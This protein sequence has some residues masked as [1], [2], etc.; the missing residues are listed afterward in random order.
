MNWLALLGT[1]L[2]FVAALLLMV[3]FL[4]VYSNG[5]LKFKTRQRIQDEAATKYGSNPALAED[6]LTTRQCALL[7]LPFLIVGTALLV[8]G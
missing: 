3:P 2:N 5:K 6:L 4:L 1:V 7:A 8:I